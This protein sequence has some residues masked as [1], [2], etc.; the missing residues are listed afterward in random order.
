MEPYWS[1]N[2]K[3]LLLPQVTFEFFQTYA[4]FSSH[5]PSYECT[6]FHNFFSEISLSPLC[7]IEKP[8]TAIIST[9]SHLRGKRGEIW[10][11]GVSIKCIQG[12]FDS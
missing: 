5:W 2:F 12:S 9:R 4:E 7:H 6:N 3:T 8:K 11:S 1:K 10:A